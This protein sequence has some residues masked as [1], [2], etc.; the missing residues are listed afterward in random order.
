MSAMRS[1]A[2][3]LRGGGLGGARFG[4]E[5]GASA[6]QRNVPRR[7]GLRCRPVPADAIRAV[8]ARLRHHPPKRAVVG[9]YRVAGDERNPGLGRARDLEE[10]PLFTANPPRNLD[11]E[12]NL[13][14]RFL[15]ARGYVRAR[16]TPV[17]QRRPRDLELENIALVERPIE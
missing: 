11:P 6:L 7:R 5:R 16:A 9:K 2:S 12:L 17:I 14:S 1:G 10:C 3:V 13:V 8:Q 4:L 15:G